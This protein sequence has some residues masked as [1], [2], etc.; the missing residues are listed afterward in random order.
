MTTLL[1][2]ISCFGCCVGMTY[3]YIV[4]RVIER[5]HRKKDDND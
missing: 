2:T 5:K 1:I 3:T 4:Y